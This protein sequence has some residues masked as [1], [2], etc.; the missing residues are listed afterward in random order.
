MPQTV[1][2]SRDFI[3]VARS[4]WENTQQRLKELTHALRVISAGER[5]LRRGKTK[6][7]GS[8]KELMR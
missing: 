3:A 8:L 1:T 4:E 5:D 7:V 2:R 6:T